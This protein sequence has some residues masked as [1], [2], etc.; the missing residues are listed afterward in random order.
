MRLIVDCCVT[1]T[2]GVRVEGRWVSNMDDDDDDGGGDVGDAVDVWW[3]W[4][5]LW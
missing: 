2:V 1:A 4:W 5:W 3:W